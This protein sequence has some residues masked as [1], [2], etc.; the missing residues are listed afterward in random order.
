LSEELGIV[1]ER[2]ELLK[3]EKK[4]LENVLGQLKREIVELTDRY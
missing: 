4:G 1:K 3:V 2:Y